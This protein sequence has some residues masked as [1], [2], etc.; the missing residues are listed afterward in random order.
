MLLVPGA[1]QCAGLLYTIEKAIGL[2]PT[3]NWTALIVFDSTCLIYLAIG[4]YFVR[5]GFVNGL[6]SASKLKAAKLFLVVIMFIQYNFILY[7]IPST[8]FWGYA[9]LFVM[10]TAFF[11][12][13]K[14]IL[15]TAI[16]IT[17][18]IFVSW[19][20]S[21]DT[22]LPVKD[23]LFIPNLIA[24]LVCLILSL[25]F[26]VVLTYLISYFLVNAKKDEM[27]RNNE[28]VKMVLDSVQHLA[29]ELATAGSS[30][31]GISENESASAEEL[32]ATSDQLLESSN[33][34]G[35]K[36][37]ESLSNLD[38][39]HSWENV[40]AENV[41]KVEET[42]GHLLEK[43]KAN[44]KLLGDLQTVNKEVTQSMATTTEVETKLSSAVQEIGVTLS[45]IN[46]ISA[47]TNLLALNASIE[48]ARA[49]EAGRGFA[50]VAQEVGNL[51]KSTKESLDEVE[52]VIQR[53]QD[54]VR[55]I[56]LHVEDNSQ[57]LIQQNEYFTSVF[58]GMQG[59][60]Q[61]LKTSVQ[62][63]DTMGK[64]HGEQ[65]EVIKNTISINQLRRV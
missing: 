27:E 39:L 13:V 8:E 57:K 42:S 55:E 25:A 40:V 3:V 23:A 37:E 4:I 61:L 59:M 7:M 45:L 64:A 31:S 33:L 16:E 15:V 58:E 24:R 50:V 51:A 26:I 5:T 17:L 49:G 1:C 29:K 10:A 38:D 30:L 43:S 56:T 9:L 65:A 14:M 54:N 53:V 46:D 2:F 32:A 47:S 41:G 20:L 48:A 6:V 34:L 52:V 44:E 21:G 22:L 62:T 60:T 19:G 18:S 63:I 28:K 36:T 12:D 35:D 11:V